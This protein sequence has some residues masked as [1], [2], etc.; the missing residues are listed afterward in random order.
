M[1]DEL[2]KFGGRIKEV[3]IIQ[4]HIVVTSGKMTEKM[5]ENL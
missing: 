5:E 4:T 3:S 2:Q 1:I